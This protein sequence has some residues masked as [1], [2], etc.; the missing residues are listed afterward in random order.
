MVLLFDPLGR[1]QLNTVGH[2]I[3][4][5][6]LHLDIFRVTVP[7]YFNTIKYLYFAR[8]EPNPVVQRQGFS[9]H[10]MVVGYP[11]STK[12]HQIVAVTFLESFEN[13]GCGQKL[14]MKVFDILCQ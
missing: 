6:P 13:P 2:Q 9:K 14:F 11:A 3:K 8:A 4:H 1:I 10:S 12:V 5:L 7:E